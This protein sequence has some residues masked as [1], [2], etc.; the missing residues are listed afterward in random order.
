MKKVLFITPYQFGY[1]SGIYN[2]AKY[3]L[4]DYD[5]E[6]VCFDQKKERI[7]LPKIKIEYVK[8]NLDFYNKLNNKIIGIYL[9]KID[10]EGS[11]F[12]F[13]L[14]SKLI[15]KTVYINNIVGEFHDF[16]YSADINNYKSLDLLNY[17]K[18]NI[19][20]IVKICILVIEADDKIYEIR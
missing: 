1:N 8:R 9:L 16:V 18:D 12:D 15:F 11:E 13:F 6:I 20:G 3:L 14:N 7:E 17:C 19:D 5:V 4:D 2:Y 10:C